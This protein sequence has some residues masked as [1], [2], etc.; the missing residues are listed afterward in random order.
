MD[1]KEAV[2]EIAKE[3]LLTKKQK[4]ND[5]EYITSDELDIIIF[6]VCM[7]LDRNLKYE[8]RN[9]LKTFGIIRYITIASHDICFTIEKKQIKDFCGDKK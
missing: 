8:M 6:K 7:K 2:K 4:H 1:K 3:L 9:Y 5:I